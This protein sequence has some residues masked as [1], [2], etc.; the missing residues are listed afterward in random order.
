ML[1]G[2]RQRQRFRKSRAT[3]SH[4]TEETLSLQDNIHSLSLVR[5]GQFDGGLSLCGVVGGGAGWA[6][7]AAAA[8][9]KEPN[10]GGG[11]EG[12]GEGEERREGGE[13]EGGRGHE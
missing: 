10:P 2:Q 11:G 5:R 7:M 4:L 6:A 13:R 1:K 12:E 9:Q 8:A 3:F